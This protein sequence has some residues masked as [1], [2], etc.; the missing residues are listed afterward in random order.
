MFETFVLEIQGDLL[1]DSVIL[2]CRGKQRKAF[3]ACREE[4]KDKCLFLVDSQKNSPLMTAK[5]LILI[6]A[7]T[8]R[9]RVLY[10]PCQV[11]I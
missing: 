7:N 3:L 5:I 6:Q 10:A 2:K 11:S 4:Q 8:K 1:A 9:V